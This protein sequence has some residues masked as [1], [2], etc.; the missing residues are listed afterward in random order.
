MQHQ[1][2]Q[3][4]GQHSG[5]QPPRLQ[6]HQGAA[7]HKQR[8]NSTGLRKQI[9]GAPQR[10]R[11]LQTRQRKQKAQHHT[12]NHGVTQH[13][14]TGLQQHAFPLPGSALRVGDGQQQGQQQEV[15]DHHVQRQ[16]HPGHRAKRQQNDGVTHK[17]AVRA[18]HAHGHHAAVTQALPQHLARPPQA[19]AQDQQR[20]RGIS[21][22]IVQIQDFRHAAL[23][24]RVEQQGRQSQLQRE[25]PKH[26]HLGLGKQP[27]ARA[28]IAQGYGQV[29][30]DS[31]A[32]NLEHGVHR[33][34]IQIDVLIALIACPATAST[35]PSSAAC[36]QTAKP[37]VCWHS[38]GWPRAG[39]HTGP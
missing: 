36:R 2:A 17:A 6:T 16:R 8:Q 19:Q 9:D 10:R 18:R 23:R 35:P 21:Q 32:Q 4:N 38:R 22:Q 25:T 33:S 15:F 31:D 26:L 14:F 37:C 39:P 3:R 27:H 29:N 13:V 28:H 5:L 1:L 7:N 30:G 11:H 34:I 24:Q 12:P 20:P